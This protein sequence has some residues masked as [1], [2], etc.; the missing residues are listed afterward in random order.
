MFTISEGVD[1][2][3]MRGP[4]IIAMV[5]CNDV[6]NVNGGVFVLAKGSGEGE[7]AQGSHQDGFSFD[8]TLGQ[9]ERGEKEEVVQGMAA[10]LGE[11]FDVKRME[12]P[13]G[14]WI[15]HVEWVGGRYIRG[16]R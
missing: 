1:L 14:G 8:F 2:S 9:L 13:D 10:F 15:W 6:T 16:I 4:A 5:L 12:A 11:A 3:R 7:C